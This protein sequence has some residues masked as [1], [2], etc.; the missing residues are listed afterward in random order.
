M[1]R[2]H[3]IL[4]RKC[5]QIAAE[6]WQPVLVLQRQRKECETC[7]VTFDPLHTAYIIWHDGRTA[8][9][10][11]HERQVLP[12]LQGFCEAEAAPTRRHIDHLPT[13]KSCFIRN[14]HPKIHNRSRITP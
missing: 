4:D 13:G 8:V 1:L 2:E 3:L 11:H 12:R 7:P 9:R 5:K 14:D 10:V 6:L